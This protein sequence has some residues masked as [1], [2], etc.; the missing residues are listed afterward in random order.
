MSTM[1]F[2]REQYACFKCLTGDKGDNVPGYPGVGPK[3]AAILLKEYGSAYNIYD[4]IP[5]EGKYKY[6]QEINNNPELILQKL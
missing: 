1:K 4:S 3:R 6:I 2:D 5:I